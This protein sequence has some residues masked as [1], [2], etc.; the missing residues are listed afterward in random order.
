MVLF[1]L[2][3][4]FLIETIVLSEFAVAVCKIVRMGGNE[5]LY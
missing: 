3:F 1:G 5:S 2:F 4:F